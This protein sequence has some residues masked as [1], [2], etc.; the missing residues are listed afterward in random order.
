MH[1]LNLGRKEFSIAFERF[2]I[3]TY[4]CCCGSFDVLFCTAYGNVNFREYV[5]W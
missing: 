4:S 3:S 1:F 2:T 5:P